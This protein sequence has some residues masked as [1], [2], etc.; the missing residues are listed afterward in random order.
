MGC[1][2]EVTSSTSRVLLVRRC[3][4]TGYSVVTGSPGPAW[5]A[6]RVLSTAVLDSCR[7]VIAAPFLAEHPADNRDTAS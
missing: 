1:T 4:A 7:F 3:R 5:V 6:A 2:S